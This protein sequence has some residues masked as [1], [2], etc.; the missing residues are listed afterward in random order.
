MFSEDRYLETDSES[1]EEKRKR[2]LGKED[3]QKEL[4]YFEFL[5]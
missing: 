1:N 4:S 2:G 3:K 5:A